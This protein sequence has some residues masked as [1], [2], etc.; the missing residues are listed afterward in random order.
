MRATDEYSIVAAIAA[1]T[2]DAAFVTDT[3]GTILAWNEAARDLLGYDQTEACGKACYTLLEGR[4]VFGNRYCSSHCPLL[5][6]TSQNEAVGHFEVSFQCSSGE[7]SRTQVSIVTLPSDSH[8]GRSMVHI[9]Q[10]LPE[11]VNRNEDASGPPLDADRFE[12]Q[13]PREIEVLRLIADGRSTREIAEE[14]FISIAT[15]RNHVQSI[16]R[17]M[18]VHSRLEAVAALHHRP[19]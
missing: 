10:P 17:K 19:V 15:V 13:T 8:G 9:L 3:R 2:A 11:S 4:D 18:D 7:V 5:S 12:S 16:L 14:L 1:S 6:M